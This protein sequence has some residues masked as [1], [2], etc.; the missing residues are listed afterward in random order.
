MIP[1]LQSGWRAAQESRSAIKIGKLNAGSVVYTRVCVCMVR[2]CLRLHGQRWAN[3]PVAQDLDQ[4]LLSCLIKFFTV[5]SPVIVQMKSHSLFPQPG[6]KTNLWVPLSLLSC[7][8]SSCKTRLELYIASLKLLPT[9]TL[10][11]C[12]KPVFKSTV[13]WM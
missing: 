2:P 12:H 11:S 13:E 4:D 1:N 3:T 8:K 10:T 5:H 9:D 6:S 7:V